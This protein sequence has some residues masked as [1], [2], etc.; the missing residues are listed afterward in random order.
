MKICS[1]YVVYHGIKFSNIPNKALNY[2]P[3]IQQN[4]RY[5]TNI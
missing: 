4:K 2:C 3:S 1:K 5:P